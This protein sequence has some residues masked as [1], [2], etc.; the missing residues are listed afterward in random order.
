M[1]FKQCEAGLLNMLVD[2]ENISVVY[3]SMSLI[4]TGV[5]RLQTEVEP[6]RLRGSGYAARA[7]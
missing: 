3:N 2:S 1:A 7:F 6:G 5:E 4:L